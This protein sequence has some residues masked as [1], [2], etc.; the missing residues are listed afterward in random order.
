M[1]YQNRLYVPSEHSEEPASLPNFLCLPGKVAVA[2]YSVRA[3][4]GGLELPDTV[5]GRMRP[6]CGVVCA[7]GGPVMSQKARLGPEC[8][9]KRGDKVLVRPYQGLWDDDVAPGTQTRFYGGANHSGVF[10][11]VPWWDDIVAVWDGLRWMPTG[12]NLLVERKRDERPLVQTEMWLSEGMVVAAGPY[13]DQSCVGMDI[14]WSETR[15]DDVL[16]LEG[17]GFTGETV[18]V[19]GYVP[20]VVKSHA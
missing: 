8:H 7:V 20:S 1:E 15:W 11:L 14:G 13:A 19:P 6:D 10:Q 4:Y 3:G 12:D 5:K 2:M 16:I 18:I 17:E 9:L